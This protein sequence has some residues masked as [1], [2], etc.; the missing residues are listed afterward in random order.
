MLLPAMVIPVAASAQDNA[1]PPLE[2]IVVIET[3]IDNED[4]A[5]GTQVTLHSVE[6]DDIAASDAEQLLQSLPGI[7]VYRP[8]GAGGTSELFLRGAES[9]FTATFLDGVRMN[10]SA[11]S[12]GGSFDYS[13]ISPQEI[14]R[15]D[16][17]FGAMSAIY[18]SDAMAGVVH[19]ESAWP[20]RNTNTLLAE[21]GNRGTWKAAFAGSL[22]L[23]SDTQAGLRLLRTDA[24]E[25]IEGS[26]RETSS[27]SARLTG[28]WL[29]E[30]DWRVNLRHVERKR[31]SFPEVSGGPE[32]AVL[33]DLEF[34]D[35]SQSS[36]VLG[37]DLKL[38]DNWESEWTASYNVRED[39]VDVPAVA[40]GELEGQP[41][42]TSVSR[43][44]RSQ[45]TWINRVG[46]SRN[47]DAVFGLD[48]VGE[49]GE[50]NG[51]IDLGFGVL[52][53]GYELDRRTAS[54]FV[55]LGS[56][57]PGAVT[58]SVALRI[59][60]FDGKTRSSGKLGIEREIS[61]IDSRIWARVANGFKLP[62]FFALGNPLF[63]NPE[64]QVEEVRNFETGLDYEPNGN[65]SVS[66]SVFTS[67]YENLVDFDFETFRNV[68]VGRIEIDG[69]EIRSDLILNDQLRLNAHATLTNINAHTGP[70]R[71]RPEEFAGLDLTWESK[72]ALTANASLRY[73]GERLITS[74]P[75]RDRKAGSYVV[76]DAVFHYRLNESSRLWFAVDNL[77]GADYE[78]SPGF[79]SPGTGVRLGV[80][81]QL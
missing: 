48:L 36:I 7:S 34:A 59:D 4:Y 37:T 33:R 43:Y 74:I 13:L 6:I 71:R 29:G 76:A 52:P 16:V 63:G 66:L 8:G 49:D 19:I 42:F 14:G 51:S 58:T 1:N 22:S 31:S 79:P 27:A 35:G 28:H 78:H 17:A 3:R 77:F 12:R 40:P 57:L 23:G 41:A 32:L 61:S 69:F 50:D 53:N 26:T 20:E 46:V 68:N 67:V 2:E 55:E 10:D 65:T 11:N 9:N 38:V 44:Q 60:R 81:L 64:L 5:V 25:Q 56:R 80:E 15:V 62:S 72:Q 18:G 21:G 30:R 24:G 70:L 39:N 75:T 54:A 45:L 47:N 73:V